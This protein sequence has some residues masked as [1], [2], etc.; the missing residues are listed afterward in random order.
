MSWQ[1]LALIAVVLGLI[2]TAL[3]LMA[4]ATGKPGFM[5]REDE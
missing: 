3:F 1:T 2:A 4:W 5:E